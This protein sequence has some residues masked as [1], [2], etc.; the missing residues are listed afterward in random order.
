MSLNEATR[1]AE[2]KVNED[3]F[4]AQKEERKARIAEANKGGDPYKVFPLTLDTVGEASLKTDAETKA[5]EKA[6]VKLT[7]PLDDEDTADA[8]DET[9]PHGI[10]PVKA[11]TLE[12]VRDLIELATPVKGTAKSN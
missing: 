12:I 5:D 10:E 4:N 11:E 3:R 1:L 9:F 7:A 2:A 6:K 8:T